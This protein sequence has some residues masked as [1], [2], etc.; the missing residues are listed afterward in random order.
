MLTPSQPIKKGNGA[1]VSEISVLL[2]FSLSSSTSTDLCLSSST[3]RHPLAHILTTAPSTSSPRAR[4]LTG[5]EE[6][7]VIGHEGA[8]L[9]DVKR[10]ARVGRAR[11]V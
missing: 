11:Y 4:Q 9:A 10:S 8:Q 5:G 7:R 1:R 6:C 3:T 2:N